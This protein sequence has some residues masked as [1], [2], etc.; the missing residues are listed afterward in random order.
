MSVRILTGDCR[1][2][3]RTLRDE[4][5]NCCVTSPPYWRQ[6]DYGAEGQI[7]LEEE[8]SDFVSALVG[9][10]DA[11]RPKLTT[12]ATVWL[13]IGEKWAAGGNGGGGSCMAKRRDT[14]WEHA[15]LARCWRKPPAGYKDKDMVGSPWSVALALR[16]DGW[17]LRQ[18]VIWNKSVATEPPRMDRPSVSHEYIFQ[19][20]KS[21]NSATRYPGENWFYSSVWTVRPT[22]REVDHPALMHE[23]IARR[24]IVCSSTIGQT[25]LDPFGGGGTTGLVADRLRRNAVLIELNPEYAATARDRLNR[26]GGMFASVAAE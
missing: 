1:D 22:P 23:E 2:V 4:S 25:V 8:P 11:M 19:L 13:N 5:I 17:W 9:V 18:C 3:L 15:R 10:F 21:A 20:S 14:A 26:D 24:C 16:E 6:R 12:D 7:G